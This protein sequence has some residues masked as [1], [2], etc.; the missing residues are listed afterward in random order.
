MNGVDGRAR[1]RA[2]AMSRLPAVHAVALRLREEGLTSQQIA[3]QLGI[4]PVAVSPLLAVAQAKLEA[5]MDE[6]AGD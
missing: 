2:Q 1:R 6:R 5:I 3:E 4:D